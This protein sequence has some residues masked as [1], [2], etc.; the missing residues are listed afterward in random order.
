MLDVSLCHNGIEAQFPSSLSPE[1][2]VEGCR[3]AVSQPLL[4]RQQLTYQEPWHTDPGEY[5]RNL[6][7]YGLRSRERRGP[8]EE[9][10]YHRRTEFLS[11][12]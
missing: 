8:N 6:K 4:I 7:K 5:V 12:L 3:N 1:M 2:A 11:F 10:Q 9:Y